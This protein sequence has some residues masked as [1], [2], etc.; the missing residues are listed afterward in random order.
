MKRKKEDTN[1]E[2]IAPTINECCIQSF[3]SQWRPE[4]NER[5]PHVRAINIGE[6]REMLLIYRTYDSKTSDP[7]PCYLDRLSQEGFRLTTGFSGEPVLL[8]SPRYAPYIIHIN[9]KE[10]TP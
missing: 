10:E 4:L 2:L 5:D 7:L 6:L 3:L 8:A 9:G 1:D